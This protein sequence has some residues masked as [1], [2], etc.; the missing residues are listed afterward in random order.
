MLS[1]HFVLLRSHNYYLLLIFL[2]PNLVLFSQ[3]FLDLV[4]VL[5]FFIFIVKLIEFNC[6]FFNFSIE[7]G[8]GEKL[9]FVFFLLY[10]KLKFQC[11]FLIQK[12][13]F[14]FQNL[15]LKLLDEL[16]QILCVKLVLFICFLLLFQFL[17]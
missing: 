6:S 7:F 10:L 9:F 11:F 17:L 15:C 3:I 1:E 13:F 14:L 4:D 2:D 5:N 16:H 12:I 8:N